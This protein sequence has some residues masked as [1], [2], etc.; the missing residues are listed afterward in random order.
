MA[1]DDDVKESRPPQTD[2]RSARDDCASEPPQEDFEGL[3]ETHIGRLIATAREDFGVSEKSAVML[4]HEVMLSI[5]KA[6]GR[7]SDITRWLDGAVSL[8]AEAYALQGVVIPGPLYGS[9]EVPDVTLPNGLRWR[10]VAKLLTPRF[11]R[12]LELRYIE[13]HTVASVAETLGTTEAF[14]ETLLARCL[15][16]AARTK[17][18]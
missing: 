3:Y 9:A 6:R 13:G 7:V 8:A 15:R 5:L 17:L 18:R 2:P 12:V 14:V 4:A 16:R 11:R 1:D 10:E